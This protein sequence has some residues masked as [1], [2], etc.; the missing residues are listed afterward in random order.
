V[1]FVFVHDVGRSQMAAA[2]LDRY[3]AGGVCVRS[4][5]R[6]PAREINCA[7]VAVMR[8]AEISLSSEFQAAHRRGRPRG[9]RSDH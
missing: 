4:A 7:V 6:V 9:R 5:G 3:A 8:E 2:L 1:L